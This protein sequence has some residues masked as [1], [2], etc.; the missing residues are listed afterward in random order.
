M[1]ADDNPLRGGEDQILHRISAQ[2]DGI[3]G[4]MQQLQEQQDAQEQEIQA[5]EDR[6]AERSQGTRRLIL[7]CVFA[8]G[9]ILALVVAGFAWGL[10]M[11][12]QQAEQRYN[13][14][15]DR[16]NQLI[17]NVCEQYNARNAKV[18][19]FW[20]KY[21]PLLLNPGPERDTVARRIVGFVQASDKPLDCN[22]A[23]S[24]RN[25]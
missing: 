14:V 1:I 22:A 19:A 24:G 18:D 3:S 12:D 9:I 11:R 6:S 15:N 13:Q 21:A 16:Y 17:R 8:F 7:R 20:E 23:A 25:P 4:Q 2:L 5:T 10:A